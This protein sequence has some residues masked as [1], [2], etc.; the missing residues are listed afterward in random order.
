MTL[1]RNAIRVRMYRAATRGA[2]CGRCSSSEILPGRLRCARCK[3]LDAERKPWVAHLRHDTDDHAA[4]IREAHD[5]LTR[6]AL[7]GLTLEELRGAGYSLQVDRIDSRRGYV[8][9]NLQVIACRL[10]RQKQAFGDRLPEWC[11]RDLVEVVTHSSLEADVVA[12]F[13]KSNRGAW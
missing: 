4:F 8:R 2:R 1:T 10:N 11:A 5:D 13:S 3:A 12:G 7:S 9:G 6:C